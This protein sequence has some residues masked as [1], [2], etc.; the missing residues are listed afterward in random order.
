MNLYANLSQLKALLDMT[1]TTHD[2]T[3]MRILEQSSRQID[4][5][6]ERYFYIWEGTKYYDGAAINLFLDDDVQTI[7]TLTVDA[8]GDNTY[9][10]TYTVD[11]NSPTSAPDVFAYPAN[12]TPKTRLEANPSGAYGNFAPGQRKAVCVVGT[13][14]HGNDYPGSNIV[15]TG[16]V[17]A[18]DMV[19]IDVALTPSTGT[20]LY[21]GM[22]LR[23]DSEQL[24]ITQ[25]GSTSSTAAIQRALN[26]TVAAVHTSSTT[27]YAYQYP[28]PIVQSCLVQTIRAW[29]RRESAYQTSVTSPDMG[30][31]IVYRGLDPDVK[32]TIKQYRKERYP[33]PL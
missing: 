15:S 24:F 19:A 22:T 13:F 8:D 11:M 20:L 33:D 30:T 25:M 23:I 26:G 14:G 31:T 28:E 29:K 5:Y 27:I 18:S 2:A 3:L 7:T 4:N 9:E 1:P 10:S 12:K 32:E 17:L 21:A 6:V 16:T